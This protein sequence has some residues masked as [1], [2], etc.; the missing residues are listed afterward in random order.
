MSEKIQINNKILV[1]SITEDDTEMVVAWR[2]NPRVINNFLYRG[3]FNAEIHTNWL[4]TKVASGEVVQFIIEF[5]ND[6]I[7]NNEFI[8]VGSVYF[9]DVN[10]DD[11][12]AEYGIFIGEDSVIGQGVG[13]AVAKWA[14]DYAREVM[15]LKTLRLRVL[16][17][18][19]S[20]VKSYMKAGYEVYDTQTDYIDGRDLCMMKVEF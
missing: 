3:P 20:A 11:R 12:T 9:R 1:R 2:N 16:A 19:I 8:P 4:N 14:V 7:E 17:D 15:R 13:S 10:Q 18:N 6:D 5:K